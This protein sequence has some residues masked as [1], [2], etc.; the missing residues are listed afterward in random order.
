MPTV[1]RLASDPPPTDGVDFGELFDSLP[2]PAV[3][4]AADKR[5]AACNQTFRERFNNGYD[6]G[7]AYEFINIYQRRASNRL[8]PTK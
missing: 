4:V 5:I 1:L 8:G 7:I 3:Y 6:A 2:D